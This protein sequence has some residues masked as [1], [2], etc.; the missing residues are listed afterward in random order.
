MPAFRSGTRTQRLIAR[1][2]EKQ[3]RA[4]QQKEISDAQSKLSEAESL[5]EYESIYSNLTPFQ[6]SAFK[7][8]EQIKQD[9]AIERQSTISKIDEQIRIARE[10][11]NEQQLIMQSSTRTAEQEK[12]ADAKIQFYEGQI[13]GLDK[14]KQR[15]E[16]GENISYEQA[17]DYA[18]ALGESKE[19]RR[20]EKL[21]RGKEPEAPKPFGTFTGVVRQFQVVDGK[22]ELKGAELFVKGRQVGFDEFSKQVN[23][24]ELN[25]RIAE[26]ERIRQEALAKQPQ[27]TVTVTEEK[28]VV[29]TGVTRMAKGIEDFYQVPQIDPNKPVEEQLPN[30]IFS[31]VQRFRGKDKYFDQFTLPGKASE[32]RFF[33]PPYSVTKEQQERFRQAQEQAIAKQEE[34]RRKEE[35]AEAKRFKNTPIGRALIKAG[36]SVGDFIT[37]RKDFDAS[38]YLQERQDFY[39]RFGYYPPTE[40]RSLF[41]KVFTYRGKDYGFVVGNYLKK[42]FGVYDQETYERAERYRV[43]QGGSPLALQ[44]I[45]GEA[46]IVKSLVLPGQKGSILSGS[47]FPAPKRAQPGERKFAISP[48]QRGT[49]ETVPAQELPGVSVR[50]FE[51]GRPPQI[52]RTITQRPQYVAGAEETAV[53][54]TAEVPKQTPPALTVSSFTPPIP[55]RST[56]TD[57][58]PERIEVGK[59]PLEPYLER[60]QIDKFYDEETGKY[61][62]VTKIFFVDPTV[63]GERFEREAT[64]EEAEFYRSQTDKVLQASTEPVTFRQVATS[65]IRSG[66]EDLNKRLKEGVEEPITRFESFTGIGG[67]EERQERIAEIES[68]TGRFI[69]GAGSGVLEDIKQK[70][71]KNIVLFGAGAVVGGVAS[72]AVSGVSAGTTALFGQQAGQYATLITKGAIA[73][74]AIYLGGKYVSTTYE[75]IKVAPTAQEKGEIFGVSLKDLFVTGAGTATGAK[76]VRKFEGYLATRGRTEIPIERI[77]PEEVLSGKSQFPRSA[78]VGQE[79]RGFQRNPYALPGQDQFYYR[80]GYSLKKLAGEDT[81][82][83]AKFDRG[84]GAYHATP[85]RFDPAKPLLLKP[86][87]SELPGLYTSYGASPYFLK[88]SG[89]YTILPL[90]YFKTPGKPGFEYLIPKGFRVNPAYRTSPYVVDGQVFRY[91]FKKPLKPG[92]ADLP[93]LKIGAESEAVFRTG[94][95]VYKFTGGEFYTTYKGVRI[96]IDVF[97]YVEGSATAIPK[98]V[99]VSPDKVFFKSTYQFLP[100]YPIVSPE[101]LITSSF[102]T[103]S[104]AG[105]T[106]GF[107]SRQVSLRSYLASL[108]ST[109]VPVSPYAPRSYGGE[110]VASSIVSDIPSSGRFVPPTSSII[111]IPPSSPPPSSPHT[112]R[113][114]DF[115]FLVGKILKK[116][117]ERRS[118]KYLYYVEDFSSKILDLPAIKVKEGNVEALIRKVQTGFELRQPVIIQKNNKDRKRLNKLLAQ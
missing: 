35:E 5:E 1:N 7:S 11:Q 68:P 95:G 52:T 88:V 79:I 38:K 8:P 21:A 49:I 98:T 32:D 106:Q 26:S 96:P 28:A 83:F 111:S 60:R 93:V 43:K 108:T 113:R 50:D 6:K 71:L 65:K 4:K 90:E 46:P 72:G 33:A 47:P 89:R 64:P 84:I 9:L 18:N 42:I 80:A 30:D 77:V 85:Y 94:S 63:I 34:E 22:E 44:D 25:K 27:Q 56:R 57:L 45:S 55:G 10:K 40:E 66:Y 14:V 116:L 67:Y 78:T 51:G 36:K 15:V 12:R 118:G 99:P 39:N 97:R 109:D 31:N 75:Q 91:A 114:R 48:F 62:P 74:T 117:E 82:L 2:V 107:S 112:R 19:S 76:A 24:D 3:E 61:M 70:P 13:Q 16:G 59:I 54:P 105:A 73:G 100:S 20:R 37:G 110:G 17:L 23:I 115:D 41:S 69:A 58:E 101:A 81:T 103:S 102:V 86:G 87:T 53:A 29:K 104:R 92:Y